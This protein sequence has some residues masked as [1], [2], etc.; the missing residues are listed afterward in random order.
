MSKG[1]R[2]VEAGSTGICT[3]GDGDT[4]YYRGYPIEELAA[5]CS[6]EEVAYLLLQGELPTPGE[7][8]DYQEELYGLRVIPKALKAALE[9]LPQHAHPMDICRI[10]VD[11]L[12]VTFPE[13]RSAPGIAQNSAKRVLA[14]LP[15]ALGH[16]YQASHGLG[17]RQSDDRCTST[18]FL[19]QLHGRMPSSREAKVLDISLIL[20]AEHE[21]AASTFVARTVAATRADTYAAISAAMAALK[22]PLHGGANEAAIKLISSQ[23]DPETAIKIVSGMLKRKEKVMGFGHAVYKE[24]DPRNPLAKELA[25]ALAKGHSEAH[26]FDVAEAIERTVMEEKGVQANLDFYA[27]VAYRFL[28]IPYELNTALFACARAAGWGAHIMEQLEEDT[29]IRPGARYTGPKPRT[30]QPLAKR[31]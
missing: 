2:G 29:L 11:Y 26:V 14:C 10:V 19:D 9:Q 23:R 20:Y 13:K 3:V 24:G 5:Q 8:D 31:A 1:L 18:A 7:L 4:L 15:A 21:F 25:A 16:W 12:A 27:S 28:G 22:G 30:V 17:V 6:F